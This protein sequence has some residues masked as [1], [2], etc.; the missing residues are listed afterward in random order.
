VEALLGG[1]LSGDPEGHGEED[2]GT[3]TIL[4]GG[5]AGDLSRGLS[6]GPCE[7]SETGNFF[8]RGPVK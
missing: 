2:S 6:T 8:H 3:D 5:S 4:H 1:F 7:G